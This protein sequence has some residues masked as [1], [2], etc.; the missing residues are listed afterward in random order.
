MGGFFRAVTRIFRKP[1][2]P[3]QVVIQQ[4]AQTATPTKVTKRT[5]LAKSGYGGSTVM[6][7]SEGVED[8]ANLSKA[9]LGGNLKRKMRF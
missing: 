7:G 9:V 6:T 4:P 3:A 2:Q 8:E 5:T 1:Q